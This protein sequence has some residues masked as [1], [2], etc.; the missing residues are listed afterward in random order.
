[1][2]IFVVHANSAQAAAVLVKLRPDVSC[3]VLVDNRV[4]GEKS[5]GYIGDY[6]SVKLADAGSQK[7]KLV[8]RLGLEPRTN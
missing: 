3:L 5:V 2:A 6:P 7:V 1:M 4:N 8:P